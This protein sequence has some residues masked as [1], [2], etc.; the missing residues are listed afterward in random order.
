MAENES[1]IVTGA[2]GAIGGALVRRLG[3]MGH[4]VT[5]VSR[6]A[7]NGCIEWDA[8][9]NLRDLGAGGTFVHCAWSTVPASS[10][11]DPGRERNIDFPLLERIVNLL[12]A[13]GGR[14]TLVFLSSGG[15]VYGECHGGARTE[16][17]ECHPIGWH[18]RMKLDAERLLEQRVAAAGLDTVIVRP[19][20]VYGFDVV[21][22][23]P[24]GL[25]PHAIHAARE[26]RALTLWGDGSA[27]KDYVHVSDVLD[28]ILAI[29]DGRQTG[30]FNICSGVSISVR[31]LLSE[32]EA[33]AGRRIEIETTPRR[34]W[35]VQESRLSHAKLTAL[36]GWVPRVS[37]REGIDRTLTSLSR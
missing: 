6:S 2:R 10:E 37:L 9:W 20:N 26:G 12:A 15:A 33:V 3:S 22:S 17:D 8:L 25:I 5:A 34:E 28:G 24:Q 21:E 7:G 19:S 23:R 1:W 35:D 18:G 11:A 32:I 29:V 4:S 30:I 27:I 36:T 14:W 16:A 13:S 31:E